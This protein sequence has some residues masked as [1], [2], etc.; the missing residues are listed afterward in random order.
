[1]FRGEKPQ[2]G[3]SRQFHQL[4]VEA[5]GSCSPYMDAEVILLLLSILQGI[6]LEGFALRLNSL[7]CR[8]DRLKYNAL[9]KESL[10]NSVSAWCEDCRQRF[11]S[12][13]LRIFD[14]KKPGCRSQISG[15]PSILDSICND[16]RTH[17]R[18]LRELLDSE[19]AAYTVD[20]Y[21]VRGLDYYSGTAF[22]VTHPGLGA[23]NAL[24]GG[25]RYDYLVTELGGS[26]PVGALGFAMG[27][28]RALLACQSRPIKPAGISAPLVYVAT[29]G[30]ESQ[31]AGFKLLNRLRK[32]GI[33][34]DADYQE[35]SIKGQMRSA[36]RAGVRFV[37]IIGED[38]LRQGIASVKEMT[39]G[40]QWKYRQE[41]LIDGLKERILLV[42]QE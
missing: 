16:C 21:L 15:L 37:I 8:D 23:Q 32:E 42:K 2:A 20:P 31:P 19:N 4:G 3:R 12:N 22:E 14:C 9:L 41:E 6:G 39:T 13:P 7:G 24:A 18:V 35:K 5:I 11:L 33:A 29:I 28:E 27:M 26:Q 25:G 10:K 17:F 40:E 30:D 1:M 36:N 34:A 38:E